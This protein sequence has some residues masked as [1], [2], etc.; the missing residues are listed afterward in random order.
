ME[1]LDLVPQTP[2]LAE[3]ADWPVDG[4]LVSPIPDPRA[5]KLCGSVGLA[6]K[7][8]VPDWLDQFTAQYGQRFKRAPLS[9]SSPTFFDA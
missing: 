5:E 7:V 4:E 3:F 1:Y 9:E 8:Y 2:E 6:F